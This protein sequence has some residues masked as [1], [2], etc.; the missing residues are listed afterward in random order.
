MGRLRSGD[1]N[2]PIQ[3]IAA[4]WSLEQ[5][6][7]VYPSWFSSITGIDQVLGVT[8]HVSFNE[9]MSVVGVWFNSDTK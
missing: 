4:Y 6:R 3:E 5:Y 9:G 2:K 8:L 7:E 1:T